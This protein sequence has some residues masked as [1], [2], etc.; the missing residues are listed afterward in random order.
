M[1]KN[2]HAI[3][4]V[5]LIAVSFQSFAKI[6]AGS[7]DEI[8]G[9]WLG[10]L[11]VSGLEL[12]IVFNIKE[13]ENGILT[14]TMD[15]PDQSA[16]GIKVDTVIFNSRNVKLEVKAARG[17]FEGIF[18]QDSLTIT[19]NWHQFDSS[20]PVLLKKVTKIE[21]A[22]RAQ[23]PKPPFPYKVEDVSIKNESAGVTLSGTLT[24]PDSGSFFP[25]VILI[26]GSGPINRDEEVFGHKP[27]LVIADYLTRKGIAVLRYDKRGIGKSTGN[28]MK[29]TTQNFVTDALSAVDYLSSRKEINPKKIGLIGHSEGGL[30][31]PLAAVQSN[32]I[33]FIVL[34]AGPGLPGEDILKMQSELI[35]KANGANENYI[36][37]ISGLNGKAYSLIKTEKDSTQLRKKLE[38]LF[39]N[40]INDLPGNERA[41]LGKDPKKIFETQINLITSPWFKY[42]LTYDPRPTLRKVKVP[43][44][45]IDGS[46]DL[47]VPPKE[48]LDAISKALSEGGNKNYKVE[49]LDGLNHL[50]QTA[51]TGSPTEYAKIEET[52]AP[53]ALN[54]IGDWIL[55]TVKKG[56]E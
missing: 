1:M 7:N 17:Y 45:A 49:E 23:E 19:G 52:I 20:F 24:I 3:L 26:N 41:S 54:I 37:K 43:V 11:K 44:L 8:T 30:I 32:K 53:K 40:F 13:S 15:S 33:D 25:A 21:E 16:K 29:A 10:K 5:C 4:V 9:T 31:A 14:A 34:M 36:Q 39:E 48:D 42:F 56:K 55:K 35:L 50:F 46:K 12:R 6:Y 38:D 18:N 22:K 2:F 51:N 27:F 28:Y 47:Q